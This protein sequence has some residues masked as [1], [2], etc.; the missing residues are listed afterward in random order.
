VKQQLQQ[1]KLDEAELKL[2]VELPSE[3][4]LKQLQLPMSQAQ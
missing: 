4:K 2:F 1:Q 3:A